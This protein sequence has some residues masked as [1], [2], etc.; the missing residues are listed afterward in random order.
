M[1]VQRLAL[2]KH[3]SLTRQRCVGSMGMGVNVVSTDA[4]AEQLGKEADD[5]YELR[6]N[7]NAS[8]RR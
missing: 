4:L 7:S 8:P 6:R 2:K 3:A 5:V 1:S